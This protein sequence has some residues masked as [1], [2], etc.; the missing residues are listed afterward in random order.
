MLPQ[1]QCSQNTSKQT[2]TDSRGGLR[3]GGGGFSF[4]SY[5]VLAS[6]HFVLGS[7]RCFLFG[8]VDK[9]NGGLR[10]SYLRHCHA[11]SH[12]ERLSAKQANTFSSLDLYTHRR[13]QAKTPMGATIRRG[14]K[15]VIKTSGNTD[16]AECKDYHYCGLNRRV[17][18]RVCVRAV[19]ILSLLQVL[20]PMSIDHKTTS[21][22]I[23]R[24]RGQQYMCEY[25][26]VTCVSYTYCRSSSYN[27][28]AII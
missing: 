6:S 3:V 5:P 4:Q 2:R 8:V 9:S 20:E 15:G 27:W 7:D 23:I 10:D 16:I 13:Y 14:E 21:A 24:K 1:T 22:S 28:W 18:T 17:G 19:F 12:H 26:Q 25:H 11:S